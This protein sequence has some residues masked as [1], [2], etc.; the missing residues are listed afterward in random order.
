LSAERGGGVESLDPVKDA[1][2][3]TSM[4][5]WNRTVSFGFKSMEEQREERE[6]GAFSFSQLGTFAV[7]SPNRT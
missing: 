6:G 3:R 1:P 2:N 5:N 4:E 7:A